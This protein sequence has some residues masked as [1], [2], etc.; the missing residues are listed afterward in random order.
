MKQ[1]NTKKDLVVFDNCTATIDLSELSAFSNATVLR[2]TEIGL[3]HDAKDSDIL[4]ELT[5]DSLSDEYRTITIIT[6]DKGG[7]GDTTFTTPYDKIAIIY[8]RNENLVEKI[9]KSGINDLKSI[10]GWYVK[11]YL[12]EVIKIKQSKYKKQKIIK[13]LCPNTPNFQK[14]N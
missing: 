5:K 6:Q 2:S 11:L 12:N 13:K 7:D 4:K 8:S 3:P 14:K 9:K 1:N 10:K